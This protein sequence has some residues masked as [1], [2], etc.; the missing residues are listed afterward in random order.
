MSISAFSDIAN[1]HLVFR[2]DTGAYN[3]GG[4]T[5]ATD[6][7]TVQ[8]HNDQSGNS[9]HATQTSG[10]LKPVYIASSVGG[11][12]A[13]RFDGS[14][15]LLILNA[16]ASVNRQACTIFCVSRHRS[17][18]T[19]NFSSL[20]SFGS[21]ISFGY[22]TTMQPTNSGLFAGA[23]AT[24]TQKSDLGVNRMV[25]G[26]RSNSS[27]IKYFEND[28]YDTA[29]ATS[30]LV[31]TGGWVGAFG[32]SNCLNGEYEAII[33][34]SAAL[35]DQQITD[36]LALIDSIWPYESFT[37]QVLCQGD[38][39]TGGT[40]GSPLPATTFQ[41]YPSQ[42]VNGGYLSSSWKVV[43][44]GQA[45]LQT[46]G[47]IS[48]FSNR[49]TPPHNATRFGTRQAYALL[50]GTNDL[51]NSVAL[52]TI[53]SNISSI[54]SSAQSAGSKVFIGTVLPRASP[55]A[56]TAP[57]ETDRLAL[58]T[59]IRAG[60]SSADVVVETALDS[61]MTNAADTA[62]YSDG[63][64]LSVVGCGYLASIFAAAINSYFNPSKNI[65][66]YQQSH[67]SL[68]IYP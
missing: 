42:M 54:V 63:V 32:G 24:P 55:S 41:D 15:D 56:L 64:H 14:N 1:L 19:T 53:K 34:Y 60:S 26:I 30:S 7:Q 31:Q 25:H 33:V 51:G 52:A 23:F 36:V 58:N 16:L 29:T 44:L 18:V 17:L 65:S 6:G 21:G 37:G 67:G 57:Q 62:V 46:S 68:F 28:Y 47:V 8:Q 3:D 2:A 13:I 22:T 20:I 66:F 38:S 35:T 11:R 39:I 49:D 61:R 50:I 40:G 48:G 5:L 4:T 59:W 43:N 45:G 9:L 10:T 27:N 12:A